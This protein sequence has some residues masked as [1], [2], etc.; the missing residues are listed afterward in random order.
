MK[1]PAKPTRSSRDLVCA[2]A[3][4]SPLKNIPTGKMFSM[5][6]MGEDSSC[7]LRA[8]SFNEKLYDELDV[9]KTYQL[10]SFTIKKAYGKQS[11]GIEIILDNGSKVQ[12]SML[13][14]VLKPIF[15]DIA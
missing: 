5:T 15:V 8:V 1:T 9:S 4:K 13:Q 3:S 14:F 12:P 2:I 6:L 10:K 11:S 7:K